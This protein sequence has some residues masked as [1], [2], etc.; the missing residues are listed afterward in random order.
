MFVKR[1]MKK[2]WKNTSMNRQ[3]FLTVERLSN[4][5]SRNRWRFHF[6]EVHFP[7]NFDVPNRFRSGFLWRK[8]R[9]VARCC[10]TVQTSFATFR[11][12]DI[13]SI[14]RR[15]IENERI[16]GVLICHLLSVVFERHQVL[17]VGLKRCHKSQLSFGNFNWIVSKNEKE[18]ILTLLNVSFK[19]KIISFTF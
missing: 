5:S 9:L 19:K 15:Q 10:V 6:L 7:R 18:T 11:R 2:G 12:T 16:V 1:H 13:S 14:L 3:N 8:V 4:D 17:I